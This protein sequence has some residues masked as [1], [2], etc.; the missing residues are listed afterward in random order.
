MAT[1]ETHLEAPPDFALFTL[2]KAIKSV[3]PWSL[4]NCSLASSRGFC[5]LAPP[6]KWELSLAEDW[7]YTSL[8]FTALNCRYSRHR[9]QMLLT[10]FW[11]TQLWSALPPESASLGEIRW[12]KSVQGVFANVSAEC[13]AKH[14]DNRKSHVYFKVGSSSGEQSY[15]E[16]QHQK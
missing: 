13:M 3:A 2:N 14:K 7:G 1:A 12:K 16:T 11:C 8:P 15:Q 4:W 9:L 10:A 5:S 6:S